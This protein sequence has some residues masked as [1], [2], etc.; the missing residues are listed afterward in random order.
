[1]N[2][3]SYYPN[4]LPRRRLAPAA[5][6]T[7]YMVASDG[8]LYTTYALLQAAGKV[9]WPGRPDEFPTGIPFVVSRSVAAGGVTDG[10]PIEIFTNDVNGP[11]TNPDDLISGSGQHLVW[12]ND[13]V[14]CIWVFNTV[15]TDLIELTGMF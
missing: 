5:A 12:E 8:V 13:G 4:R 3:H 6:N 10:S 15:Q 2:C 11:S 7:W 9:P 14:K 1:M